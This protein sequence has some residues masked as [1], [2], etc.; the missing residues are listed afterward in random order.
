MTPRNANIYP[1]KDIRREQQAHFNAKKPARA[2]L[3]KTYSQLGSIDELRQDCLP[4]STAHSST[5]HIR[6]V[7]K[8]LLLAIHSFRFNKLL[9]HNLWKQLAHNAVPKSKTA[10]EIQAENDYLEEQRQW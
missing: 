4:Y 5:S 9:N 6:S 8:L 7:I 3:E 2:K 10:A 1:A